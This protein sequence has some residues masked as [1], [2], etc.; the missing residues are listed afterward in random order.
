MHGMHVHLGTKRIINTSIQRVSVK[1]DVIE[2]A[3]IQLSI[4]TINNGYRQTFNYTQ[5]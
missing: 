2:Y 5:S 4:H 3:E 1:V